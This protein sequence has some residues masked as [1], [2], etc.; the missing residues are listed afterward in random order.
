MEGDTYVF[1]GKGEDGML[2]EKQL[3]MG[4]GRSG[5]RG[6]AKGHGP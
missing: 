2:T 5:R 4:H 6:V 1:T 3:V